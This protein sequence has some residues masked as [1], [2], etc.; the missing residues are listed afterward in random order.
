MPQTKVTT[1]AVKVE[2]KLKKIQRKYRKKMLKALALNIDEIRNRIWQKYILPKH[3]NRRR[4]HPTK[5]TSRTDTLVNIFKWG[6]R[7]DIK[8]K[9]GKLV[10]NSK[11]LKAKIRI[12]KEDPEVLY[13][14]ILHAPLPSG[15]SNARIK[16]R[17]MHEEIG[18]PKTREK[19]PFFF[20]AVKDQ[21][22]RMKDIIRERAEAM[23][24][25]EL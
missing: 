14:G 12:L 4:V 10:G 25:V 17:L 19:R 7:W 18:H 24:N 15:K 2:R 23:R 20:P 9:R 6:K 16:Y 22:V 3:K 1:N 13:E 8:T 21:K 5:L 11:F